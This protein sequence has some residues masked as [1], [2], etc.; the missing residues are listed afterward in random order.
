MAKQRLKTDTTT[1]VLALSR[2]ELAYAYRCSRYRTLHH[3]PSCSSEPCRRRP[4]PLVRSSLEPSAPLLLYDDY[5]RC[6]GR[7]NPRVHMKPL[8]RVWLGTCTVEQQAER[9]YG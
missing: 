6:H 2:D 4:N 9:L 7:P 8:P 5:G 3:S 1:R